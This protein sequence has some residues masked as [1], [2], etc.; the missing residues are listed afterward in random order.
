MVTPKMKS[1][2]TFLAPQSFDTVRLSAPVSGYKV[3]KYADRYRT[4]N[5][6]VIETDSDVHYKQRRV[7]EFL[8]AENKSL[9]NVHKRLESYGEDTE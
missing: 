9:E 5:Y 8:S 7:I 4:S 2:T 1:H 6:V 3:T